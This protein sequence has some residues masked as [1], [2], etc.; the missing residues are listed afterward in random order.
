MH[1]LVTCKDLISVF[2]KLLLKS[3]CYKL[4]GKKSNKFCCY[5]LQ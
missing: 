5:L 1:K 2:W 4:L 3:I